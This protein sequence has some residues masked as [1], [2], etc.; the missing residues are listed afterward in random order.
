MS[1][2]NQYKTINEI[3][4]FFPYQVFKIWCAFY[5]YYVSQLELTT[6]QVLSSYIWL[7]ATILA[8]LQVRKQAQRRCY[9]HARSQDWDWAPD[10]GTRAVRWHCGH[11]Q[12]PQAFSV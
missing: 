1:T 11:P 8:R 5:I 10:S 4:Y 12:G 9:L 3:F 6:F 2:C 7:V